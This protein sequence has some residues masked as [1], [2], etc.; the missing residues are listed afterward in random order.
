MRGGEI[1]KEKNVPSSLINLQGRGPRVSQKSIPRSEHF[2]GPPMT[3]FTGVSA[4]FL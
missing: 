1:I 3:A 4:G 2:E